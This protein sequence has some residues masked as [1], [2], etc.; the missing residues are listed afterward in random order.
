MEVAS[1]ETEMTHNYNRK[2]KRPKTTLDAATA[3]Q[4]QHPVVVDLVG[5]EVAEERTANMS[6]K[7]KDKDQE[8]E[9]AVVTL[10]ISPRVSSSHGTT[11]G[12]PIISATTTVTAS[13]RSPGRKK[14]KKKS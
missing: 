13:G 6:K 2:T 5:A 14:R 7:R 8:Q 1:T 12:T 4:Q 10:A 9:E 11:S 3:R